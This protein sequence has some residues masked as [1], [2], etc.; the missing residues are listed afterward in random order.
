[1]HATELRF[2]CALNLLLAALV[3]ALLRIGAE[4]AVFWQVVFSLVIA[5][6][7]HFF[8]NDHILGV[9]L[10]HGIGK[11]CGWQGTLDYLRAS[12][13]RA[14]ECDSILCYAVYGSLAGDRFHARSDLD[15][16]YL[17]QPGFLH[18]VKAVWFTWRE[19]MIG[20]L[21]GVALDSF[22]ADHESMLDRMKREDIPLIVKDTIGVLRRRYPQ[23]HTLSDALPECAPPQ[24]SEALG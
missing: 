17:R 11:N 5:R 24:T 18:G 16:R 6:T 14:Q 9:F 1:M 20:I 21:S 2:H 15:V 10:F 3:F 13:T 23:A 22:L 7:L 12:A 8:L 4:A 19:R